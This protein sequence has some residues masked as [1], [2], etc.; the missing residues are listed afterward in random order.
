LKRSNGVSSRGSGSGMIQNLT[1]KVC[2]DK[3]PNFAEIYCADFRLRSCRWVKRP[4]TKTVTRL[5]T[6]LPPM[7]PPVTGWPIRVTYTEATIARTAITKAKICPLLP[8]FC[9]LLTAIFSISI[10]WA[11]WFSAIVIT[12]SAPFGI[13]WLYSSNSSP[14]GNGPLRTLIE[15]N[16]ADRRRAIS[17]RLFLETLLVSSGATFSR[18]FSKFRAWSSTTSFGTIGDSSATRQRFL[19]WLTFYLIASSTNVFPNNSPIG[20]DCSSVRLIRG[21]GTIIQEIIS[22]DIK[23]RASAHQKTVFCEEKITRAVHISESRVGP[24]KGV[25]YILQVTQFCNPATM[26]TPSKQFYSIII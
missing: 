25:N 2:A 9:W 18:I 23:R 16:V 3:C 26:R 24:L 5:T 20:S 15:T 17:S 22:P 7:I 13:S 21:L 1:S 14:E 10:R 6:V 12:R 11:D 4:V 8:C 19:R